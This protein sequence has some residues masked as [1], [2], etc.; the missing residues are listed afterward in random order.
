MTV[1]ERVK[2]LRKE[3]LKMT[4]EDFS[5]HLGVGKTAITEIERG[6]NALSDQMCR[7]ICREFNVN[8]AWLRTGEGEM[9]TEVADGDALEKEIRNFLGQTDRGFRD[10]L[11]RMLLRLPEES[12]GLLEQYALEL[13]EDVKAAHDQP[14]R[15]DGGQKMTLEEMHA[16]LDRQWALQQEPIAES[17]ASGSGNSAT[18]G[19]Q[20]GIG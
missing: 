2:E 8:E 5:R 10:R 6:R 9:F 15:S 20:S 16:E 7:S 3:K 14:P 13:A 4:Q 12:W 19:A 18:D 11:V 17:S 1:G